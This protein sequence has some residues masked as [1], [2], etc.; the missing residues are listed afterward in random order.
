M[1]LTIRPRTGVAPLGGVS[2]TEIAAKD[3]LQQAQDRYDSALGFANAPDPRADIM[4]T[5]G[6]IS[7]MPEQPSVP[8]GL[9][10]LATDYMPSSPEEAA[11]MQGSAYAAVAEEAPVVDP[12]TGM[13]MLDQNNLDDPR[14]R[15]PI[16]TADYQG[17]L[18]TERGGFNDTQTSLAKIAA[19]PSQPQEAVRELLRNQ[20]DTSILANARA[21]GKIMTHMASLDRYVNGIGSHLDRAIRTAQDDLFTTRSMS[22]VKTMD[23]D[24]TERSVPAGLMVMQKYN[25]PSVEVAK[26]V[27]TMGGIALNR[28]VAQLGTIKK[29]KKNEDGTLEAM[30]APEGTDFLNDTIAA[31]T[32]FFSNG[33]KNAG[34]KMDREDIEFMSKSLVYGAAN[35]GDLTP[36]I[37]PVSGRWTMEPSKGVR[38]Q[39]MAL[40]RIA[41]AM[42]GKHSQNASSTAPNASGSNFRSGGAKVSARSLRGE[43][44]VTTAADITKNIQ[45]SIAYVF[46]PKDL[47]RKRM[48]FEL[49]TSDQ[50][51]EFI[52][53]PDGSRIF[54]WSNHPLAKRNGLHYGAFVAA[55]LQ[56]S[57]PETFDSTNP[58]HVKALERMRDAHAEQVMNDKYIKAIYTFD[59]I[60]DK[61]GLRYAEFLHSLANQRFF[62]NSYDLDYMGS[63]DIIRDVMAMAYQ[64]TVRVKHLFDPRDISA[65]KQ[66]AAAVLNQN[67]NSAHEALTKLNPSELGAMGTM[68]SST[69]LYYTAVDTTSQP[70]ILKMAIADV[71]QLYN[72]GIATKLG[73]LG[74]KYN[75]F[76]NDPTLEPDAEMMGIW[77][78]AGKGEA[79]GTL[80]L[81]DD[82][83]RIKSMFENPE[84]KNNSAAMTHHTFFDGN[85]NGIFLQGLFFG[86][87]E[88]ITRLS[89][90]NPGL[91]D[92]RVHALNTMV[93]NLDE[94]LHDSPEEVRSAW[95]AFWA[96]AIKNHPDGADGVAKD[97]FKKPLM[98][99]AYGKDASMFKSELFEAM[100]GNEMYSKLVAKHLLSTD[101]HP[102]SGAA[103]GILSKAVEFTLRQ[104]VPSEGS[105]AM[106]I[107]GR[108]FALLNSPM[109][110]KGPTGDTYS[111]SPVGM[112][113]I[114]KSS[115]G[116]AI[117]TVR[118]G[119]QEVYLKTPD[120]TSHTMVNPKTG[121]EAEIASQA[122]QYLPIFSQGVKKYY[123]P[124]TQK[125]D[126]FN[127]PMGIS[128]SRQAV[129]LLIQALDGDLV[130]WSTIEANK[131][132]KIP[133]P[134]MWVHDSI[135]STPGQSLIYTNIYNN[136]AIPG[137]VKEIAKLGGRI[138]EALDNT[139]KK[140]IANVL[141][142]GE[143]VGIGSS[144]EF[145]SIGAIFDEF[146]NKIDPNSPSYK[147][148]KIASWEAMFAKEDASKSPKKNSP[149]SIFDQAVANQS[150]KTAAQRAE[151]R[152]AKFVHEKQ[153]ILDEARKIGWVP[154]GGLSEKTRPYIAV[155]AKD[156]SKALQ[157]AEELNGSAGPSSGLNSFFANF[158]KNVNEGGK[159]LMNAN[160]PGRIAQMKATGGS[161]P[162][163][164]DKI[165]PDAKIATPAEEELLVPEVPRKK[166]KWDD[167]P[168]PFAR[169]D[170]GFDAPNPFG[171]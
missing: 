69:I 142:R 138:K 45:G 1:A 137:A 32:H 144:G 115:R 22:S 76:L 146:A 99:N 30:A 79:L 168:D 123:N 125:F 28:A 170:T 126:E 100:E 87:H 38:T 161:K 47:Q 64:D 65:L 82:M 122:L 166:G 59:S 91:S 86:H 163:K 128:L 112:A 60:R 27:S 58:Q 93:E 9:D 106:K 114:N 135:I 130:K 48:E 162:V 37:D 8:R 71:I 31:T 139:R 110:V 19:N 11:A 10:A 81:L 101:I 164:Y 119:D 159:T 117:Q 75:A 78:G 140:T 5:I 158:A 43:E 46:R 105:Y 35:R 51:A 84:T 116:K 107:I 127:N 98:Q 41:D 29:P 109:F 153:Q 61:T 42:T 156:F 24:G 145:A 133:R 57:I 68:Y 155:A 167:I 15:R 50:F 53:Q 121:E 7:P 14:M 54:K 2:P 118:V 66:K 94:V 97:F 3:A 16:N 52:D 23:P 25:E 103:A 136:V 4:S 129:V 20:A 154:Q 34:V 39:A 96:E 67:G 149:R 147:A 26:M 150:R 92:M 88:S 13:V 111:V 56:A 143:P 83:F 12:T 165:L 17:A 104:V 141:E 73:D 85:Q 102:D 70:D 113:M 108:A 148:R 124:A 44:I 151:E 95:K 33:L 62:I 72:P 55:R 74:E 63:K 132:L 131:G 120:W 89:Q 80:N 169:G 36:G 49:V 40:E 160:K 157:L 77:V 152:W 18:S 6:A 134:V 21:R 90:A 171:E